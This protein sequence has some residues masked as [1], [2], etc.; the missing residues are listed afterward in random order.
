MGTGGLRRKWMSPLVL[1]SIYHQWSI[2]LNLN[3]KLNCPYPWVEYRYGRSRPLFLAGPKIVILAGE[4]GCTEIHDI[5]HRR[6]LLI[7]LSAL[8]LM[9]PEA[10]GTVI[11]DVYLISTSQ[12]L[13]IMEAI[14]WMKQ[15]CIKLDKWGKKSSK[16]KNYICFPII[17]DNCDR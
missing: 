4:V 8:S 16:H 3:S 7:L 17:K 15:I 2:V 11:R 5:Y 14:E 10:I 13:R 6:G 1:Y 9:E 12:K